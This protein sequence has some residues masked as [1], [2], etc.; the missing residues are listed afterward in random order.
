M[1]SLY[2]SLFSLY[3]SSVVSELL[4]AFMRSWLKAVLEPLGGQ[5]VT[6]G[7]SRSAMGWVSI[8]VAT[9]DSCQAE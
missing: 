5:T 9:G 7:K 1:K 2:A 4:S 3:L 6:V 8:E